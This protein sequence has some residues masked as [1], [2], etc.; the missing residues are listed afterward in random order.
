MKS[1]RVGRLFGIP[2]ELDLTFL[3]VLPLFAYV[4]G[5][6]VGRWTEILNE[7]L[8]ANI[9]ASALTGTPV[10]AFG[11]GTL[12]AVG[13]FVGVV[14]HELGHSLVARR[15]GIEIESIRL[16]LFGG[17]AQLSAM[18][19]DWKQELYVAL[20]GPAVS[21][22]LGV[23]AWV[24]FQFL[25]PDGATAVAAV[26]FLVGY[27]ALMNVALAGFNLLPGFPMDG[28]RV[29]RAL[30]ART[31]PYA[32]ATQ[33]AARVGQVFAILLGLF[34]LFGGGGLFLVAIAFF[35][36]IGA[37]SEAQQTTMRAALDGVVVGELM[38]PA[39]Q[40]SSVTPETSVADLVERMFRERHTGY[41][42]LENGRVVGLVTLEDAQ[43][44]PQVERDAYRVDDV[45]S[46]DLVTV[47]PSTGAMEAIER[48][49]TNGVGR[50]VVMSDPD[51]FRP[52]DE[53]TFTGL[54]SRT[55]LMTALD[56]I[57]SSGSLD[58]PNTGRPSGSDRDGPD[59]ERDPDTRF[60]N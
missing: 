50:L 29:L 10:L 7:L 45:M 25:P 35:I 51:P 14:L 6:Q 56:I 59:P 55:D 52:A 43:S 27:L 57:R 8:G 54:L 49:Q 33:T 17:V 30:L 3:L 32:Q 31:R 9:A 21:V 4:I 5:V 23:G 18:P 40:V 12:A 2:I 15:Y 58:R 19:E 24:G 44:V 41:P 34:G 42:V 22:L 46:T 13:L 26:K 11:M 53:A 36:Y 48:M 39:E 38:T 16:W 37:S 20:A 1:F 60:G 47:T 28:G